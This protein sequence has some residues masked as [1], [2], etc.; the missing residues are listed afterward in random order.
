[1]P[2]KVDSSPEGES[3]KDLHRRSPRDKADRPRESWLDNPR[4]VRSFFDAVERARKA[5]I[6]Q[7]A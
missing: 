1:V 2:L 5:K 3:L 6:K 4:H 7:P